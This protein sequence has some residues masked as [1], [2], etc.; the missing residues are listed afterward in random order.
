M[1]TI[2]LTRSAR[3]GDLRAGLPFALA[4]LAVAGLSAFLSGWVPLGFSLVTVFLFAGPH[5]WL[6]LRY[7][8]GRLA[9]RLPPHALRGAAAAGRPVVAAGGDAEPPGRRPRRAHRP[10]RRGRPAARRLQS[11]AGGDAHVPGDAA[12][13]HL[14]GGDP[15]G[16]LPRPA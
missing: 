11:S 9:A 3:S 7:F 4:A 13:R 8:M 1:S 2:T 6:E 10:A 16:R 14:G 5:N 12:L 15:A